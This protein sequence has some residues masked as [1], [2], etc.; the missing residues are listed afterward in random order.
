MDFVHRKIAQFR[1][2]E[3]DFQLLKKRFWAIKNKITEETAPESIEAHFD[4]H[5]IEYEGLMYAY[6]DVL[7]YGDQFLVT[8][9]GK[10]CI[11][12]DQ[13]CILPKCSC[14]DAVLNFF[15]IQESRNKTD[16]LIV[17]SL[18]YK[19]RKWDV[20]EAGS[21]P[22]DI[23]LVKSSLF[24]AF[25]DFYKQIMTRHLKLKTIYANCKKM[26]YSCEKKEFPKKVGRNDPCPCGSGKKFK[27]CCL[28]K[29]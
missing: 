8:I 17:I 18:D 13:Y 16:E 2:N 27:K 6:N 3:D 10:E 1:L 15:E 5:E 14:T 7:P 12:F 26:N 21:W 19:K 25:P 4:Y 11:V 9:A 29:L 24:D 28:N 22:I 23:E 20:A